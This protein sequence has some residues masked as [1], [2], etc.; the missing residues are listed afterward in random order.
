ME[1]KQAIRDRRSIRKF[2]Q[3]DVE[4]SKIDQ[5]VESVRLCQSAKN[6]QPWRLLVL[7]GAAKDE[8]ADIMLRL[9]EK[10]DVVLPGYANTSKNSAKIIQNAPLLILVFREKE[11][12]FLLEDFMSIGAA[13]EHLCL[14]AVDLGLGA[15]WIR[16]TLYTE[17][18]ICAH[19]GYPDLQLISGVA[20]GYPAESPPQRPRKTREEI[21]LRERTRD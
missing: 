17:D 2:M 13:I 10:K 12:S 7:Q 1:L 6:R 20:V 5:L 18:E 3:K 21:L 14:E 16:D 9:F 4:E 8:V 11:D 19:V 15:V